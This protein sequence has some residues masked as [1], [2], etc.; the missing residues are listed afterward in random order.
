MSPA[1]L[2]TPAQSDDQ[3]VFAQIPAESRAQL[4]ERLDLYVTSQRTADYDKLYDLYSPKTI[5]QVFKGQTKTEF[6]AAFRKGDEE[7][8]SVRLIEFTP[9]RI[10][11]TTEDGV[12]FYRIYG[13]AKLLQQGETVKRHVLIEAYPQ[14]GTWYFS[15]VA[16]VQRD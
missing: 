3:K 11:K 9:K 16:T 13:K 14:N 10:E 5:S 12:D 2:H 7:R 6:S 8:K 15:A 1:A 4:I